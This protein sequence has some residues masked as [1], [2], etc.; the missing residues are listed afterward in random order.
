MR[1]RRHTSRPTLHGRVQAYR[2][3][4]AWVSGM[5]IWDGNV[6]VGVVP[7]QTFG[8]MGTKP[9]HCGLTLN[10]DTP[11]GPVLLDLHAGPH[12]H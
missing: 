8:T 4:F 9:R 1:C 12:G 3:F 11:Y 7:N 5:A 2:L 6:A 10:S